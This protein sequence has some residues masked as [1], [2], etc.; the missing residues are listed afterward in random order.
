VSLQKIVSY[1]RMS[2]S[3]RVS[4]DELARHLGITLRSANRLLSKI[5]AN[6]GASCY[7]ESLKGGRGRPKKCYNLALGGLL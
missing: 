3:A 1:T 7:I 6:G 5:E 4:A 2:R